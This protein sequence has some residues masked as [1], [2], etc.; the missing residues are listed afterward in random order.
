MESTHL[1]LFVALGV[2]LLQP[3]TIESAHLHWLVGPTL[4]LGLAPLKMQIILVFPNFPIHQDNEKIKPFVIVLNSYP[5]VV[6]H[7]YT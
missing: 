7:S 1:Q 4:T 6:T 3:S 5:F 2:L